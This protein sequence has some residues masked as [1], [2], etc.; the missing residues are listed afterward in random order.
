MFNVV[1]TRA[2]KSGLS[3]DEKM[4]LLVAVKE[5]CD[6]AVSRYR[7]N[8]AER[9]FVWL[10]SAVAFGAISF[11]CGAAVVWWLN[12]AFIS[13]LLCVSSL[14]LGIITPSLLKGGSSNE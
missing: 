6:R 10:C 11:L 2:Y 3:H 1:T 7:A 9:Q 5:A 12:G 13:C 8:E 14:V 4:E